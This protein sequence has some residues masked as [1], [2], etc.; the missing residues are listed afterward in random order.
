M[1]KKLSPNFTNEKVWEL[2]IELCGN[3]NFE[4]I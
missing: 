3:Y 4:S 1:L 2:A